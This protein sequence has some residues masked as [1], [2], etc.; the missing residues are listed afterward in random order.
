MREEGSAAVPSAPR[1]FSYQVWAPKLT[2]P[3]C[4]LPGKRTSRQGAARG[5]LSSRLVRTRP[6]CATSPQSGA[7]RSPTPSAGMHRTVV[8]IPKAFCRNA[9]HGSSV[10]FFR[11]G[12]E[13]GNFWEEN[14]KQRPKKTVRLH[15]ARLRFGSAPFCGNLLSNHHQ[16]RCVF[17][18]GHDT[19]LFCYTPGC[20]D[21]AARAGPAGD[22]VCG[23]E[24]KR[25][26][27][28]LRGS[29]C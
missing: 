18:G 7:C 27:S 24:G 29:A 28:R 2:L 13:M 23:T 25:L 11:G 5:V 12:K 15:A 22:A 20:E 26:T 10:P 4:S 16:V 6:R 19:S 21:G 17:A 8:V 14:K 9:P 3:F 1:H